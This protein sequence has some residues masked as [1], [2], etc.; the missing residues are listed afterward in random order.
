LKKFTLNK[1]LESSWNKRM[2]GIRPEAKKSK[3]G[4]GPQRYN[5]RAAA[6]RE[7]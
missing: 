2:P 5:P 4:S 6:V 3:R 1:I 7:N